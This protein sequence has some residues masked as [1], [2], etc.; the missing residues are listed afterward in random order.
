MKDFEKINKDKIEKYKKEVLTDNIYIIDPHFFYDE[1]L[2]HFKSLDHDDRILRFNRTTTDIYL[3]H[4]IQFLIDRKATLLGYILNNEIVGLAEI[5]R[6]D[7]NIAEIAIT[8]IKKYRSKHIGKNLLINTVFIAKDK[9][10]DRIKI[11]F[12]RNNKIVYSW[13]KGFHI[14]ICIDKTDCFTLFPTI[15]GDISKIEKLRK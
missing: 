5:I 14:N 4:Y 12:C 1:L 2:N 15:S 7:E 3:E 9:K 11:D 13:T 6:N 8:V 10:Y